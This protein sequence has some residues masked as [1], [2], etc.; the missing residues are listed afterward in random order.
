MFRR[1]AAFSIADVLFFVLS[2][3]YLV[4]EFRFNVTLLDVAG[5]AI[6]D[7]L[8]IEQVADFGRMVSASGFTLLALGLFANAG[9][10]AT[11][12][13]HRLRYAALAVVCLIPFVF[14]PP[15]KQE[16]LFIGPV[17]FGIF[18]MVISRG[19]WVFHTVLAVI[20]TAWPAM[21][22]GQKS[23]IEHLVVE[24]TTWQERQQARNL[25]L[26]KSG[27][28]DC[29]VELQGRWLCQGDKS[30]AEIRAVRAMIAAM[31]MHRPEEI[32]AALEKQRDRIIENTVAQKGQSRAADAY[33]R[34]LEVASDEREKVVGQMMGKYYAPYEK[35]SQSYAAAKDPARLNAEI[36]R[37]WAEMEKHTEAGWQTYLEAQSRYRS[38]VGRVSDTM[39]NPDNLV[40]QKLNEFC[41]TRNCPQTRGEKGTLRLVDEAETQFIRKTGLPPNLTEKAEMMAYPRARDAFEHE[42]NERLL[43]ETGV[44]GLVL[45]KDW[46]YE[47]KYMK[48]T[49]AHMFQTQ[50]VRE[51]QAKFKNVPPGLSPEAFFERMKIPAMPDMKT[52]V[53]DQ[54]AFT[55]KYILPAVRKKVTEEI[56]QMQKEAPLY[57]NG[58]MLESK[59]RDYVRA[60]YL[61]AIALLLSLLIVILTVLRGINAAMRLGFE[62]AAQH[63]KKS[64][65]AQEGPRG[66]RHLRHTIVAMLLFVLALGP[67]LVPN[68]YTQTRVYEV[69]L[70]GA[71]QQ[72]I[73]TATLLDWAIHMQPVVYAFVRPFMGG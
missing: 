31:W 21:Y 55:Q 35:A 43:R 61:P 16:M 25:L 26:L 32:I 68:D 41:A 19:R 4:A 12:L 13:R 46:V 63:R 52:L 11:H 20:L 15:E 37:I 23:M 2:L 67:Y 30:T 73:V 44:V 27:L 71:R 33:A 7:P 5:S 34:Y 58:Q 53:M 8:A 45:P 51:W 62:A 40:F 47:E 72:N 49:L 69:Y 29:V 48:G 65:L 17:L 24:P 22:A 3:C 57:A 36:D 28:E 66:R 9:F 39:L 38:T 42:V 60:V 54:T 10:R 59:G 56:A 18:T 64:W 6:V 1:F 70:L 14:F 50:V